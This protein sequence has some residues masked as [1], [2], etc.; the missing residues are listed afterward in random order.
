MIL[1][2][3]YSLYIDGFKNMTTGKLLWKI[4]LFKFIAFVLVMKLFFFPNFLK[5]NFN[6]DEERGNHVL[7]NLTIQK[8]D[9]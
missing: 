8:G 9:R 2:N 1:K 7:N 5:T 6:T 4:I 3:I